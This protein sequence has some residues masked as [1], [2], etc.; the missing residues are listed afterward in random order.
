MIL[1]R[2]N[3][4][5]D[6]TIS[7]NLEGEDSISLDLEEDFDSRAGVSSVSLCMCIVSTGCDVQHS[8]LCDMVLLDLNVCDQENGS[9]E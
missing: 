2:G 6:Q 8:G 7:L 9:G 1:G 5:G 4:D 3:Q